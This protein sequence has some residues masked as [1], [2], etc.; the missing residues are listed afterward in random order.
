MPDWRALGE[1]CGFSREQIDS[2]APKL[3]A[4]D[5]IL[6]RAVERLPLEAEPATAFSP[7]AGE[8]E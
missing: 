7:S 8:N 5:A 4:L 1:A 3:E 6:R 2:A